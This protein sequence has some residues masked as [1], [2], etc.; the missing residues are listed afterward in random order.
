[1]VAGGD[2]LIPVLD[3]V[4]V[5][6]K[7]L[8]LKVAVAG[9]VMPRGRLPLL[10]RVLLIGNCLDSRIGSFEHSVSS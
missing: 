8:V 5:P 4:L 9:A 2:A 3:P 1:M 7:G 6:V 10:P